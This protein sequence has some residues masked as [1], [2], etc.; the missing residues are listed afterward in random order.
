MDLKIPNFPH[1]FTFPF[2][3]TSEATCDYNCIA[4][5]LEIDDKWYGQVI[6]I[7]IGLMTYLRKLL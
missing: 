7:S 2:E 6:I 4:W 5:A 3:K 1:S